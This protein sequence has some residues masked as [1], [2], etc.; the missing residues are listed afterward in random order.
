MRRRD[1]VR[2]LPVATTGLALGAGMLPVAGC[3]GTPYLTPAVTPRGLVIP[4]SAVPPGAGVFVAGPDGSARPLFVHRTAAGVVEAVLASC[5]HRGCQ[6]EPVGDRLLCPCHGSEFTFGGVVL[7][8]P[9]ERPLDRYDVAES[10]GR[11]S[12]RVGGGA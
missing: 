9:A 2:R 1:F 7:N 4:S 12:I 5:T 3:A 6:P 10:A 11:I 8:G